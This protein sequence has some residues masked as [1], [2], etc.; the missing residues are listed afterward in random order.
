M[1]CST[2]SRPAGFLLA[3]IALM[4]FVKA[5]TAAGEQEN[6]YIVIKPSKDSE[7]SHQPPHVWRVI[8][9]LVEEAKNKQKKGERPLFYTTRFGR[10]KKNNDL[11]SVEDLLATLKANNAEM[12]SSEILCEAKNGQNCFPIVKNYGL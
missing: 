12:G 6:P 4:A 8:R 10:R 1:P 3:F 2:L 5:A 7:R 9:T 11:H